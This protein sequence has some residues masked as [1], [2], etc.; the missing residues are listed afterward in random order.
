M[1]VNKESD[2]YKLLH[3]EARAFAEFNTKLN[4]Y[5][6]QKDPNNAVS[7]D[8]TGIPPKQWTFR[9]EIYSK[10][11]FFQCLKPNAILKDIMNCMINLR[12]NMNE[13]IVLET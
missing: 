12:R 1:S 2:E 3:Q 10:N 4:K 9:N 13:S 11:H 7:S 8:G 6:Q 5:E